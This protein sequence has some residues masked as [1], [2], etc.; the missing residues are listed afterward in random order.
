MRLSVQGMNNGLFHMAKNRFVRE[1]KYENRLPCEADV[2]VT[3]AFVDKGS[4]RNNGRPY[5]TLMGEVREVR[6]DFPCGVSEVVFEEAAD[7]PRVEYEY[8]LTNDELATLC[9][10]G[11]FDPGFSCPDIFF[12]NTFQLPLTC[13]CAALPPEAEDDAP[14]LFVA[15]ND[16]NSLR[17][18]SAES[19]YDIAS[20]FP[21]SQENVTTK[22]L[23]DFMDLESEHGD[24]T[25]TR[26]YERAMLDMLDIEE[27]ETAAEPEPEPVPEPVEELTDEDRLMR[28]ALANIEARKTARPNAA[29]YHVDEEPVEEHA[30]ERRFEAE[31]EAE[32]DI[33]DE[34]APDF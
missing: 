3:N 20:Y 9:K 28:E 19:G 6:G 7:R 31:D 25:S 16:R 2:F 26:E 21:Q 18:N 17:T 22:E 14:L 5:L 24:A 27:Q 11:L 13:D 29:A 15:V 4:W 34:D 23:S 33:M 1:M 10:A 12:S 32:D 30:D 8:G